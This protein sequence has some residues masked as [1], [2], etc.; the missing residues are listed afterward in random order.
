MPKANVSPEESVLVVV[1]GTAACPY[2]M[3][4]WGP[5]PADGWTMLE[6]E[7][8]EPTASFAE[9]LKVVLER[10]RWQATSAA[11]VLFVA[12]VAS[13]AATLLARRTL[14][15]AL[16]VHLAQHGGGRLVIT[17][18]HGLRESPEA[19]LV[20]LADGLDQLWID[21]GVHVGVRVARR[22]R[23]HAIPRPSTQPPAPSSPGVEAP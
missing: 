5:Q 14:T 16:A 10:H 9:R 12:G 22:R 20:A 19:A 4:H 17:E 8:Y 23:H 13:S 6:Q 18:G 15:N 2:W 21:M 3:D 11:T 1:E 7:E